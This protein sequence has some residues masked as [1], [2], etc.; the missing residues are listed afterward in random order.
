M[1]KAFFSRTLL[2]L[3]AVI[4]LAANAQAE[5]LRTIRIGVPDQSAGSQPLLRGRSAWR[6]S[7]ISWKRCLNRRVWKCSGSFS[8]GRPGGE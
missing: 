1:M 2:A 7:A 6:L 8:R 3:V 4:G 5:T